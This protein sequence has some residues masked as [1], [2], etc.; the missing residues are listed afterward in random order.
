MHE[1]LVVHVK[2]IILCESPTM[3]VI[4][5]DLIAGDRTAAIINRFRPLNVDVSW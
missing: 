5:I 1:R 3:S 4:N 2:W